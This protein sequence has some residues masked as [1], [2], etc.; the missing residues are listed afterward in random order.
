MGQ[1]A[2]AML[3][4][5]CC[6]GC[7]EYLG[8]GDDIPRLCG[9]C[10]G[11]GGSMRRRDIPNDQFARRIR[12]IPGVALG[13]HNDRMHWQAKIG[14]RVVAEWYPTNEKLITYQRHRD[15]KRCDAETFLN[16]CLVIAELEG[17]A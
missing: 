9:H 12:A 15:A 10:Q 3:D 17:A 7:G 13:I 16:V 11:Q 2:E 8:A 1:Y 5:T 4:G 14:G 6:M